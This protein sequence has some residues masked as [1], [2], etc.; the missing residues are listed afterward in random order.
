MT[1]TT[2]TP[3]G[4]IGLGIM[5]AAMAKNLLKAGFKVTVHNRSRGKVDELLAS[6]ARDGGSPAGVGRATEVVLLCV[7]DTP[8]V[9]KVLF[10]SDGVIE[11]IKK[12][13]VVIDCST[14]SA[15]ATVDFARRITEKGAHFIDS[16]ISGGPKGAIDRTVD[17]IVEHLKEEDIY[18]APA[19]ATA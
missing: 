5:G 14:I 12:D 6:G 7:P 10:G 19:P 13:A 9:E 15:T 4:F 2:D 3:V 1:V 11:S 17:M 8:D 18:V 16:P